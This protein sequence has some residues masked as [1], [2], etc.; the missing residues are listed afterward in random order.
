MSTQFIYHYEWYSSSSLFVQWFSLVVTL[1]IPIERSSIKWNRKGPQQASRI[2][3]MNYHTFQLTH[4]RVNPVSV[5]LNMCRV[6][7]STFHFGNKNE[8]QK[9]FES[10]TIGQESNAHSNNA[11]WY[12]V[13]VHFGVIFVSGL[14]KFDN[15]TVHTVRVCCVDNTF[16][17]HRTSFSCYYIKEKW[18][19][20]SMNDMQ[21]NSTQE[22]R[23]S[24]WHYFLYAF[25]FS[26]RKHMSKHSYFRW[27]SCCICSNKT[28]NGG[29]NNNEQQISY[30][31]RIF[32]A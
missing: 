30:R 19:K 2:S 29:K 9:Q 8:K 22:N 18:K 11:I 10:T 4:N 31:S 25:N 24:V 28:A 32:G 27:M 15:A 13:Y 14:S 7:L 16:G 26:T 1:I 6:Q 3:P 21:L 20:R 17:A 12:I 23:T 5:W